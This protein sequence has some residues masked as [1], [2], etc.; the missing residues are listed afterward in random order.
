MDEHPVF[1]SL[2]HDNEKMR[3]ETEIIEDMKLKLML[4]ERQLQV[5]RNSRD[6]L[7]LL[8][9]SGRDLGDPVFDAAVE[10]RTAA[11][12]QYEELGIK[13][14]HEESKRWVNFRV[15]SQRVFVIEPIVPNIPLEQEQAAPP[16]QQEQAAHPVEPAPVEPTHPVAPVEPVAPEIIEI[17]EDDHD[18][19]NQMDE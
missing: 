1:A 5:I 13:S 9:H 2:M 3:E 19:D 16:A 4:A 11:I 18:N 12:D 17:H 10:R 15:A 14:I 8:L 6:E 7:L